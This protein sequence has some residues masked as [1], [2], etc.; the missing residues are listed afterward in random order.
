MSII[1]NNEAYK[2]VYVIWEALQGYRENCISTD[3][4]EWDSICEAMAYIQEQLNCEWE[5]R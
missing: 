3:N 4:V 2:E 1:I 5:I